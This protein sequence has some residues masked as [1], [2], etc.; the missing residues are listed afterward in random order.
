MLVG[1]TGKAGSGKDTFAR[2]LGFETYAFAKPL[3]DALAAMGFPEPSREM[4]EA[5]V[6]GFEFTWRKAAQ[7]LGTEWGR[8]LQSDIWLAMAK[9]YYTQH[10]LVGKHFLVLTD[11][12]FHNE[13]DWVRENG[14]LCHMSG[15]STTATGEHQ[16]HASEATL[17][18]DP[19][20]L[21]IDNSG[22]LTN[23]MLEKRRVDAALVTR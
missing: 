9:R 7:T 2:M 10:L 1:I 17:P 21:V 13:A 4:K 6:P 8:A 3:K 19:R 14:I 23:L 18:I 11:V 20:D 12:R 16:S 5:L 15:R 22:S